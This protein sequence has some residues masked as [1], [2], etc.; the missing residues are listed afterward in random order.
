MNKIP[1]PTDVDL[2]LT[3][4]CNLR[5]KHCNTA[6]TWNLKNELTKSEIFEVFDQL[7][8]NKIFR[9]SLFGGEPFFHPDILGILDKLNEY[10]FALS[11]LTNGTLINQRMID[12]LKKLR[13]LKNI[14][15]SLD[16]SCADIHDWQR[17]EGSFDKTLS[18]LKLLKK[19]GL[20]F[21]LKAIINM[22]NYRDIE[23]MVLFARKIGLRGMDFGD[24][25]ECGSAYKHKKNIRLSG[26]VYRDSFSSVISLMKAYPE[27]SFGGTFLQMLEMLQDFYRSKKGNGNRG[28]FDSCGA[29]FNMLSIRSD[30]EVVPCSSFWTLQCGNVKKQS[31]K[32]I[33]DKSEVLYS[34][35]QLKDEPLSQFDN[36]AK[37]DYLSYCNGG[38]RAAAYYSSGNNL[39]GIN[40]ATCIV[41]SD[42]LGERLME[43]RLKC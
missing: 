28:K 39:K 1:F 18:A 4:R 34:L 40:Y 35:R 37:C 19:S 14:Q 3:G 13:F 2:A 31:L 30:G 26:Q 33:W 6:D 23:N 15:V 12:A 22:R 17:G 9:L 29:G 32:E 5:C 36:C 20:P 11:I 10:P 16:G 43:E 8:E 7:K 21:S 24:A 41:F 42:W 38:C 27:F 25:V